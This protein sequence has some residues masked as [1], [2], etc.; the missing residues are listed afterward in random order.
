[1][2]WV[3]VDGC[4]G[5]SGHNHLPDMGCTK[6]MTALATGNNGKGLWPVR[7][8]WNQECLLICMGS[9]EKTEAQKQLQRKHRMDFL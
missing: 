7:D 8:Y 1:M 6:R 5:P 9:T 4:V 3:A 2:L